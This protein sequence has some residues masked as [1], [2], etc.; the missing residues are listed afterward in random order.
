MTHGT[1]LVLN[2]IQCGM[3]GHR[4]VLP[5]FKMNLVLLSISGGDL[6]ETPRGTVLR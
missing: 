3:P 1:Q 2:L 5:P 4:M 6:I